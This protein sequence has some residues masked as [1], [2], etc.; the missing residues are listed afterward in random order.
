[1]AWIRNRDQELL[2]RQAEEQT[3]RPV[4]AI[5]PAVLEPVNGDAPASVSIKNGKP[6]SA[7]GHTDARFA[8]L[9][10][11]LHQQVISAMDLSTVGGMGEDQLRMEVRKQA[12]AQCGQRAD[13]LTLN[14]RERLVKEVLDEAFGLGPLEPLM[15]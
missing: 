2:Q 4:V 6:E 8:R 9:K 7:P 10:R 12:E 11:E 14:E 1:M 15:R 5:G 3:T 13:L